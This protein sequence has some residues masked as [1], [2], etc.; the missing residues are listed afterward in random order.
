MFVQLQVLNTENICPIPPM[1]IW[2][3]KNMV[4]KWNQGCLD[5]VEAKNKRDIVNQ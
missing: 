2:G 4:N 1:I 5:E 3:N